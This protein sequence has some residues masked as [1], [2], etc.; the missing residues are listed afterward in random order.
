MKYEMYT[1]LLVSNDY[2]VYEFLSI[3]PKGSIRKII[4]FTRSEYDDIFNLGFG[5]KKED[6]SFDDLARDNNNDRN[7]ILATV[8]YVLRVFFDK[9]PNKWVYFTGSTRERTRLYRIAITHNIEELSVDFE[10]VGTFTAEHRYNHIPFEKGVNFFAF[11]VRPKRPNFKLKYKII[12]YEPESENRGTIGE[13]TD[14]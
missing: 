13:G 7:K 12:L 10:I 6:G 8:A 5:T 1:E 9:Y 3:G 2:L 11:L 4:E 14:H